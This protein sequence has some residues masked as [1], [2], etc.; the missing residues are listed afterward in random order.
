MVQLPSHC[1]ILQGGLPGPHVV[2]LG[3]IHGDER[4]GVEVIR[5]FLKQFNIAEGDTGT[6]RVPQLTGNVTL[7]FGNPGAI[8]QNVRSVSGRRDLNRCFIQAELNQPAAEGESVE[9]QRARVIAPILAQAD[10]VVDIHSTSNE[11]PPFMV[12]GKATE[13]YKHFFS[14]LPVP[15]LLTDPD[16]ILAQDIGQLNRG[17]TD[18]FVEACGGV[19]FGYETGH[20]KDL[21]RVDEIKDDVVRLLHAFGIQ[22]CGEVVP[23]KASFARGIYK[24]SRSIHA[25]QKKFTYAEGMNEGWQ[26]VKKDQLVGTYENGLEERVPENGMLVFPKSEKKIE[27]GGNLYYL[28]VTVG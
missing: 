17:T 3:G 4:A 1:W 24:L 7:L 8:K 21:G 9:M 26:M 10:F 12:C 13:S 28:A 22:G 19:G 14:L 23:V 15:Y 18:A 25:Q 16:H 11:S 20:E 2:I 5:L 27:E 6:H